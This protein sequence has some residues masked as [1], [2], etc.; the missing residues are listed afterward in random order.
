MLPCSLLPWGNLYLLTAVSCCWDNSV[1][2]NVI[3]NI[4]NYMNWNT[5]KGSL[6]KYL[7]S[8]HSQKKYG[9]V[10][11]ALSWVWGVSNSTPSNSCDWQRKS[12]PPVCTHNVADDGIDLIL[13]TIRRCRLFND[14][15]DRVKVGLSIFICL[16][17]HWSADECWW[18]IIFSRFKLNACLSIDAEPKIGECRVHGCIDQTLFAYVQMHECDEHRFVWTQTAS[19]ISVAVCLTL[20]LN[21]KLAFLFQSKTEAVLT[22]VGLPVF[23]ISLKLT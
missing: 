13:C 7:C 22:K 1:F 10:F 19:C 6:L 8:Q 17:L 15:A 21:M 3:T 5:L 9:L 20:I 18:Q 16:W 4:N 12:L 11:Q 2:S 23:K 14:H